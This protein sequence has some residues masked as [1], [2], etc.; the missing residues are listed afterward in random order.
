ML[1]SRQPRNLGLL[2]LLLALSL[3]HASPPAQAGESG[4]ETAVRGFEQAAAPL[5]LA[6]LDPPPPPLEPPPPD[7]PPPP[8]PPD[9]PPPPPP[10]DLPPPPPPPDLPP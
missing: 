1:Q 9:L 4:S 3:A 6:V 8:P 7:L 10:P 2:G 5:S